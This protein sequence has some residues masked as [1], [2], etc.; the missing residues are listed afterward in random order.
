MAEQA[1]NFTDRLRA[2]FSDAT[3]SVAE[4]RGE[5]TLEVPSASWHAVALAL[6]DEFGFEQAVD[7]S[8]VDYLGYGNSFFVMERPSENR[9]PVSLRP[10]NAESLQ[11]VWIDN[12]ITKRKDRRSLEVSGPVSGQTVACIT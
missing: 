1:A 3:V 11:Q 9:P 6:R 4:P 7:I 12:P 2:R 5:I 10:V 8:G